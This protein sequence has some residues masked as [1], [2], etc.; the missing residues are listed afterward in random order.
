[1]ALD[2]LKASMILDLPGFDKI[3]NQDTFGLVQCF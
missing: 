3:A 2:G 1:M